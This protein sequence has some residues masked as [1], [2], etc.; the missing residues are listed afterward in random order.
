MQKV[1]V[2]LTQKVEKKETQI[3]LC[4]LYASEL[5]TVND[6]LVCD[7]CRYRVFHLDYVISKDD[8]V[9]CIVVYVYVRNLLKFEGA[10]LLPAISDAV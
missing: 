1:R 10:S 9:D 4:E 2:I 7:R 8:D 5:P 3:Q 6:F